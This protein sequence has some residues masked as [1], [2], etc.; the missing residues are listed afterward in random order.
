MIL[1]LIFPLLAALFL[2]AC[3]RAIRV[4]LVNRMDQSCQL[5]AS[6]AT[7]RLKPG[8]SLSIVHPIHSGTKPF[9]IVDGISY[10]FDWPSP[11]PAPRDRHQKLIAEI[12]TPSRI[13][14]LTIDSDAG[15]TNFI[16][17]T[18]N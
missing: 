1:H 4:Q 3:T 16:F 7:N 12:L 17:I 6:G 15:E 14:L 13:R 10:H 18:T 9:L 2:V 8:A 11:S 5:V